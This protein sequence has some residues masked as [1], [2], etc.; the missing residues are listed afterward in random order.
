MKRFLSATI[1]ALIACIT[2]LNLCAAQKSDKEIR[3]AFIDQLSDR[4]NL[5][6]FTPTFWQKLKTMQNP[7]KYADLKPLREQLTNAQGAWTAEAGLE[8]SYT[9]NRR[10][11]CGALVCIPV[12][13]AGLF[14]SNDNSMYINSAFCLG[15]GVL[16]T[17]F[18]GRR[19]WQSDKGFQLQDKKFDTQKYK[20]KFEDAK[21]SLKAGMSTNNQALLS[22]ISTMKGDIYAKPDAQV[23]LISREQPQ[24]D[25]LD[26]LI[27]EINK[28]K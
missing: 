8:K 19:K 14:F 3:A 27:S 15:L 22:D 5:D 18:F 4:M 21:D 7:Q 25:F 13:I 24:L 20:K 16:G 2:G 10:R 28:E 12:G 17:C 11:L 6:L 26:L 23:G 1:V 9:N